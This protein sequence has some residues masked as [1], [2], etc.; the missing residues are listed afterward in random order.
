MKKLVLTAIALTS[1]LSGFAQGTVVFNN[2]V[3]GTLLTHI[4][5]PLAGSPQTKQTGNGSSDTPAGAVSWG[6]YALLGAGGAAEASHYMAVLLSAPGAGANASSLL[7]SVPSSTFRTGTA[8][9]GI[10]PQ[11][12]TL[13]N[14]LPDA[15]VATLALVA[16]DNTS[17]L[18]STWAQASVAWNQGLIA[19][20]MSPLWNQ[21]LI[22]GVINGAPNMINSTDGANNHL[23]SFNIYTI[24]E[25]TSFALAGLGAAALM[26]F[27]RRK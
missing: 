9:G 27:R 26:I 12:A 16:W 5:A 25:P 19:A 7:P 23:S 17:G 24:P 18:Y 4:Y 20:G 11:T 14:V 3:A 2:R 15:A 21:D 1:A 10:A 13:G 6:G 8:A 22:G